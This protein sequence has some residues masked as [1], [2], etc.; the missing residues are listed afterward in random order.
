M[1]FTVEDGTGLDNSNAYLTVQEWTDHHV[2]RGVAAASDGTWSPDNIQAGIVQATDYVEK[3]FGKRF[4]GWKRSRS[5]SL[6]WPRLDAYD[7]DDHTLEP[8]PTL[9]KR[10]VAEYA[11]L[12]LQLERNL[13][14][15]PGVSFP[16]TDP[17]TGETTLTGAGM[18]TRTTEKV[19]VIEDTKEY[20][21]AANKPM[22]T[23]GNIL[24]QQVPEYPQADMWIEELLTNE[25]YVVRG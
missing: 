17:A 15:V 23:S 7:D 24:T 16:V 5:Q 11:L 18:L 4:R 25:R 10:G 8:V 1:A 12:A 20:E 2:D 6:E 19:D 9:L 14:P 13:A 21:A 22:V 3:R